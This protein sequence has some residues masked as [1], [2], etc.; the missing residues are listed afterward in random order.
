MSSNDCPSCGTTVSS[1]AV[2]TTCPDCGIE[3]FDECCFPAGVL[4]LCLG[5]ETGEDEPPVNW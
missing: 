2:I 1:E 4:T 5:C 3:G